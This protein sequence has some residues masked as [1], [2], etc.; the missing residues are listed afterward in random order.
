MLEFQ[1]KFFMWT[2][3]MHC[4]GDYLIQT[5]WLQTFKQKKSWEEHPQYAPKYKY[6][7]I[8]ALFVHSFIYSVC[9][10]LYPILMDWKVGGIFPAWGIVIVSTFNHMW[11]DDWKANA[12]SINLIQDQLLHLAWIIIQLALYAVPVG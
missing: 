3:F 2:L 1:F 6:D 10:N 5:E 4:I 9:I 11:I 8:V 7:Y 12:L